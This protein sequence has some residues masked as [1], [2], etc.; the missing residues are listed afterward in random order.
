MVQMCERCA[1]ETVD[2]FCLNCYCQRS[3]AFCLACSTQIHSVDGPCRDHILKDA[4]EVDQLVLDLEIALTSDETPPQKKRQLPS[5]TLAT[6]AVLPALTLHLER[7]GDLEEEILKCRNCTE[8]CHGDG[9]VTVTTAGPPSWITQLALSVCAVWPAVRTKVISQAGRCTLTFHELGN[10]EPHP[11]AAFLFAETH[12]QWVAD[13]GD[14]GH[15]ERCSLLLQAAMKMR[16][17]V[18]SL[19]QK[20]LV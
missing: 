3:S 19:L 2:V 10:H 1:S 16:E 7:L 18:G 8:P 6:A 20:Q 12:N 13:V 15:E 17:A 5:A 14:V 9:V 11:T 4:R